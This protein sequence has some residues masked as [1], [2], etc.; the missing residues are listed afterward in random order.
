MELK[1]NIYRRGE[2]VRT[3]TARDYEL[4]FGLIEDLMNMLDLAALESGSDAE[5]IKAVMPKVSEGMGAAKELFFDI[6]PGITEEDLRRAR[7]K[8]MIAVLV[9]VFKYSMSEIKNMG[10]GSKN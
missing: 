2:I 4:S 6:F 9:S 10:G 8:D 1:L 7:V 5:V 3:Y